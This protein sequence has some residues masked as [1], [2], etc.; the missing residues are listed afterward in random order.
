MASLTLLM[1][2]IVGGVFIY[3]GFSK[4]IV[5]V[6]NFV[7]VIESYQFVKPQ[8]VQPIAWLLPWFELILGTFLLTGFLTRISAILLSLFSLLFVGLLSRS[9]ILKLPITECGCF[10]AG[11]TLTPQQALLLD[12]GLLFMAICIII[13]PPRRFSL[14]ARLRNEV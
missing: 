13:G 6:E 5:P 9:L 12:L 14:D 7:A 2:F 4:L 11:I 1:R 3:S 8:F 10:G